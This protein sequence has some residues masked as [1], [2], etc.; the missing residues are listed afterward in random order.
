MVVERSKVLV[1]PPW[2]LI[3]LLKAVLKSLVAGVAAAPL[4]SGCWCCFV[5]GGAGLLV[6]MA[7]E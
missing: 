5:L 6:P 2:E 1:M 3:L 4:C 7:G